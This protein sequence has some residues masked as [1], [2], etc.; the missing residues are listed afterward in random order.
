MLLVRQMI[1]CYLKRDKAYCFIGWTDEID[2]TNLTI[3]SSSRT[4]ASYAL[5]P[6]F[7]PV[8]S[9]KLKAG[10]KYMAYNHWLERL[11]L[12]L[13]GALFFA[14]FSR[15]PQSDGL[16]GM[17]A[18]RSP[19]SILVSEISSSSSLLSPREPDST[20]PPSLRYTE[21]GQLTHHGYR[22]TDQG[23][24]GSPRLSPDGLGSQVLPEYV[25]GSSH[26]AESIDDQ[27]AVSGDFT[28]SDLPLRARAFAAFT[29][30]RL[31]KFYN[32]EVTDALGMVREGMSKGWHLCTT[33]W[34]WPLPP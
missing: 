8:L 34:H 2:V 1:V 20:Q 31:Q 32:V 27:K 10:S 24:R 11:F 9:L 5:Q 25:S 14:I 3:R 15:L 17:N 23:I 26:S 4:A 7:F 13:L 19:R 16:S 6:F 28:G 29:V 33:I 21:I 30:M 22:G 18:H 12:L